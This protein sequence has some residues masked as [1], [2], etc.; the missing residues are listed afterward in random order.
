MSK[1]EKQLGKSENEQNNKDDFRARIPEELAIL[2]LRNTVVFPFTILPL[3]VGVPRSIKLIEDAQKGDR[4]IGLVSMKDPQIEEPVPGQIYETGT[5]AR[6]ERVMELPDK[7][8]HVIVQGL[9]RFRIDNWLKESPYLQAHIR[10]APDVVAQSLEMDARAHSLQELAHESVSPSPN[11]P[12]EAGNLL[13]Q[14]KD[15][16]YLAY[17]VAVNAGLEMP[18][19]QEILVHV[20]AGAV[21]KDG[22][23]AGIAMAVA[24][25]SLFG[26]RPV[27]GDIGMTGEVTLRGRVL[28]VGG[29]KMKVLAAHRAGLTTVVLPRR[30][31]N[32]LDDLPDEVRSTMRFVLVD[33]IDEVFRMAFAAESESDELPIV[34]DT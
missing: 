27:R 28:A 18:K 5:V 3:A 34:V 17:L 19:A 8:L 32:D 22:P 33:S 13:A 29:V 4:L 12:N 10:L 7:T 24:I 11:L 9:E 30:N 2:P 21:P 16:R 1:T 15:P 14:V 20:P 26:S 31:D 25:A 6:I 23:S